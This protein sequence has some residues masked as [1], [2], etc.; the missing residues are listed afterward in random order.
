MPEGAGAL[1]SATSLEGVKD[2]RRAEASGS[3]APESVEASGG[4]W[5]KLG[6][7]GPSLAS[8][9]GA[10]RTRAIDVRGELA[11][12]RRAAP[13]RSLAAGRLGHQGREYREKQQAGRRWAAGRAAR[14]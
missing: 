14:A 6:T 2:V 4:K 12:R 10:P 5:S 13:F 3:S 11:F 9:C 7:W 1:I 8:T